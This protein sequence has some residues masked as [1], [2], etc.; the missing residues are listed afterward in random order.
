MEEREWCDYFIW[1]ET[2]DY[3]LQRVTRDPKTCALWNKIKSKLI[4]FWEQDL[5]PELADSRL[6]RKL[7]PRLPEYRQLAIKVA[8]AM[9]VK[10]FIMEA[11]E[12]L[13]QV[14]MQF[15]REQT[16]PP[17]RRRLE[18]G[19]EPERVSRDATQIPP[20]TRRPSRARP[21]AIPA[22]QPSM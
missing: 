15:V 1:S 12:I 7:K 11:Q 22:Q 8:I 3:F 5:L 19:A 17:K 13:E 21:T 16:P 14:V 10:I 20:A 2:G 4:H 18:A 6:E 9:I